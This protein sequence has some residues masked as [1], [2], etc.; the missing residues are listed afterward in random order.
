MTFFDD[1]N[2]PRLKDYAVI[3]IPIVPTA[4]FNTL[5]VFQTVLKTNSSDSQVAS[6]PIES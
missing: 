3:M 4:T 1:I 6:K 5:V 2:N